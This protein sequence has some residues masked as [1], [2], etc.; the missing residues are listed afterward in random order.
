MFK[1]RA[2]SG[3]AE[4]MSIDQQPTIITWVTSYF[5]GNGISFT[6][7]WRFWEIYK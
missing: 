7:W 3:G 6:D 1:V 5:M 2:C 4:E